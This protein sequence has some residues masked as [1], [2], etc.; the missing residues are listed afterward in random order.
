MSDHVYLVLI[1]AAALWGAAAGA[2]LPRAAYR[3]SVPSG[4]EWRGACP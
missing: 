4:E 3:F 2:V 1:V